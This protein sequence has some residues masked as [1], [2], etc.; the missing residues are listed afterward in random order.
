MDHPYYPPNVAIPAYVPNI[1]PLSVILVVSGTILGT[2]LA[3]A[4]L[5]ARKTSPGF[6]N[7]SVSDQLLF[8]WFVLCTFPGCTL[9]ELVAQDVLTSHRWFCPLRL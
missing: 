8:L 6:R 9:L 5:L 2:V 7:A 1:T 4:L 3:S